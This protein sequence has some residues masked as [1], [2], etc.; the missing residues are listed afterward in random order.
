MNLT[1]ILLLVCCLQVTANAISQITLSE[2]GVS[3]QKVFREIREQS[4]YNFLYPNSLLQKAGKVSVI[5]RNASLEEALQISLRNTGLTY[6]IMDKS[7]VIRK[8]EEPE[9]TSPFDE[10]PPITVKGRILNENG[11]PVVASIVIKGT[12]IGTSTD[13]EGFFSLANVN[14]KATLVVSGIGIE[15]QEVKVNGSSELSISVAT[16]VQEEDIAVVTGYT[17]QRKKDIV[18]SVSVVDVKAL[19]SIP[20]GSAMQALQGQAAGVN[21]MSNGIPGAASTVSVRGFSNLGNTQP[22]VIIDGVQGNINNIPSSDVE[23]IQVLKDAGTASIYGVRGSNGVIIITTKKGKGRPKIS[24]DSYYNLQNPQPGNPWSMLN[25]EEYARLFYQVNPGSQLFIGGAIPDYL[26]RGPNGRGVGMEGDAAVNP[27]KY[28]LDPQNSAN[29]YLIQKVNKQGTNWFQEI[30][31][32]A[33]M[34]EHNVTA[35][36]SNDKASYMLSLNYLDQKGTLLETYQKRYGVRINTEFKPVKGIR[37]GENAYIMYK[38]NPQLLNG[39]NGSFNVLNVARNSLPFIP[40]YDIMGNYGGTFAGP[41]LGSWGNPVAS[42][43][44]QR[45]NRRRELVINGNVYAE[46]DFLKNFTARTSFGGEFGTYFNQTF[47]FTNPQNGEGFTNPNKLNETSGFY[48]TYIWTNTLAYRN[49]FGE[50][51]QVNAL[52]GSEAIKNYAR[53]ITADRSNFFLSDFDYLVLSNGQTNVLNGSSAAQYSLASLFGQVNYVFDD[54]YIAQVVVR[55]D[56]YSA[57]GPLS[58]YGTFPSFS[59][60]W[61]ISQ[62]KFMQ[63]VHWLDD[64]KIR[65]SHGVLGNK[66][67]VSGTNAF[68]LYNQGFGRS[69]YAITGTNNT[70]TPGF[71]PMSNGNAAT[72][73]EKNIMTNVGLDVALFRNKLELTIDFYN[74]YVDG[75]LFNQPVPATTGEASP[76]QINLG[77]IQNKGFD[78]SARYRT[79][80][81]KDLSLNVLANVTAYKNTIKKLP[82]PGYV[83]NGQVR[84][85]VDHPTSSFFGYKVIGL[86]SDDADVAKSAV[87]DGAAPGRFKYEDVDGSGTIT[88]D[89]RTFIGDPNPDFTYGLNLGLNFRNFDFGAIFYG[90]QGNDAWNATKLYTDF[91]ATNLNNKSKRLLNAWTPENKSNIPKLES[92]PSFSTTTVNHSYFVEDASYLR[93]RSVVLGYTFQPSML[94]KLH[95]QSLRVYAQATNLFTITKYSGLDP[96]LRGETIYFGLDHGYYPGN[97]LGLVFGL[98]LSF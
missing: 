48:H 37:L 84:N 72:S 14:D 60:G 75:L 69:Y 68:T 4:G 5:V 10:L 50:K 80:I 78:F 28:I 87:Q 81:T 3:L 88:P 54:K 76:P 58:K 16:K 31:D 82:D 57:F 34:M 90:S 63:N 77:D 92:Q 32:P 73:W 9:F 83:D 53:N 1:A 19:K 61:R 15:T 24:Y 40:V 12:N 39:S 18:G 98:N 66:E 65:A 8:K 41:E 93:L 45:N 29:N 47:D 44:N 42:L 91:F 96:E 20:S 52:I 22:L 89:D 70:I 7:I 43:L 79:N 59:V 62:E 11:E 97:Q 71:Y 51:H 64:L 46:V 49:T 30:F 17:A 38:N 26:W 56:G 25:T 33:L 13:A 35:S 55:R 27:A 86:F 85:Q 21:V 2:R 6:S 67:N 95:L 74:K 23:S 36:G 94:Q